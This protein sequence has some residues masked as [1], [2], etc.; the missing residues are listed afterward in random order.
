MNHFCTLQI[1]YIIDNATKSKSRI[2]CRYILLQILNIKI[3]WQDD[4][5]EH[6]G[7]SH[8]CK[9]G[10]SWSYGSWIYN[11]LCNQCLS[12]L[13]WVRIPSR[14]GV[15][16]AT[17][18]DKVCQQLATGQWFSPGTLVSSINKTE[19]F[20]ENGVNH[21]KPKQNFIFLH[22]YRICYFFI[23]TKEV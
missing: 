15:L 5:S 10:P 16:N 4:I 2:S 13:T 9:N 7:D 11:Y 1:F 20:F 8:H 18:C 12:P 17:L 21:H 3:N 14:R 22:I 19:I 6:F 23:R